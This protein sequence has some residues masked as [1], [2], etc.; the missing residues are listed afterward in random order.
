MSTINCYARLFTL[1]VVGETWVSELED[2]DTYFNRVSEKALLDYFTDNFN[3]LNNTDAF[4][5][6]LTIPSWWGESHGVPEFILQMENVQ[7]KAAHANL[8]I[9]Y[10]YMA[11]IATCSIQANQAFPVKRDA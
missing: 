11:T 9:K 7:K 2:P 5:I 10:A 8:P 4:N 1:S 6:R 3:G